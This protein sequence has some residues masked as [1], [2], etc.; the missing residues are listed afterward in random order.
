[1]AAGQLLMAIALYLLAARLMYNWQQVALDLSHM[2]KLPVAGAAILTLAMLLLMPVGWTLAM[3]AAGVRMS[4]RSGFAVYYRASILRY[5]PGA[6]WYLPGRAY[7]C[8]KEGVSLTA[9]AHSALLE[10]FFSLA[11]GGVLAGW[12]LAMYLGRPVL[13]ALSVGAAIA[14]ILMIVWPRRL[15]PTHDAGPHPA[16]I[17]AERRK[18]LLGMLLT[19][20]LVWF[21][22]GGAVALMLQALPGVQP[23]DLLHMV[24]ANTTAWAAGF[25]SLA[26]TGLGVRELG[27]S[28][29]LGPS[30]GNA[31]ILASF[32]QRAIELVTEILLW[33]V[34][35]VISLKP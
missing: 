30:L 11:S 34:A 8:Q 27:L 31:A 4:L 16:G 23:P 21:M 14:I 6:V 26:P 1:M 10:L 29:M 13:R 24:I 15:F 32:G 18:L 12:G 2:Q 20:S 25:V 19:Y 22:F 17:I 35:R 33:L 7:L 28:M 3:R 9:F 5:L